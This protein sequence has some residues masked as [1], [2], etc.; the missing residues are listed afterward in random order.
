MTKYHK[1]VGRK[2]PKRERGRKFAGDNAREI[3]KDAEFGKGRECIYLTA[4]QFSSVDWIDAILDYTGPADAVIATWT[5]AA[6]DMRKVREW[7]Q[8]CRIQKCSWLV[9]RSF[10]N[11]SP[12]LAALMR[13][14]FGDDSVRIYR[15]H[16]KFALIHND[17]WKVVALTSANLNQN[18]RVEFF[19]AADDPDLFDEFMDMVNVVFSVQEPGAAWK[20]DAEKAKP[21]KALVEQSLAEKEKANELLDLDE[22]IA[23]DLD[24]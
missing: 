19:Q 17:E 14:Q 5:A 18:R 13:E 24:L 23:L 11:H 12:H 21:L 15:T 4:G 6:A 9:D 10:P 7:I 22:K 16:A 20:V 1:G 2:T 8:N 3:L